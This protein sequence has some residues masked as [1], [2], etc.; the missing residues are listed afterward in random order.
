MSVKITG[1]AFLIS[2]VAGL[3]RG[4]IRSSRIQRC[5]PGRTLP[6]LW[7]GDF[8]CYSALHLDTL[9]SFEVRRP[10]QACAILFR[11]NSGELRCESL[12]LQPVGQLCVGLLVPNRSHRQ[13][14]EYLFVQ[15]ADTPCFYGV[16]PS[17][18]LSNFTPLRSAWST[19]SPTY[20]R[21]FAKG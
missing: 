15:S 7:T 6:G 19:I 13:P 8:G 21:R 12:I 11:A 10:T 1:G 4:R 20:W 2:S 18:G 16:T 9:H 3:P 17:A 5:G 14:G